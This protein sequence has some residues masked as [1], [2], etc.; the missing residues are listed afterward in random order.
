[1]PEDKYE[2]NNKDNDTKISGKEADSIID[3]LNLEALSRQYDVDRTDEAIAPQPE[4]GD[5]EDE[6]AEQPSEPF[7][8]NKLK[9]KLLDTL[10]TLLLL[11]SLVIFGIPM[12]IGKAKRQFSAALCLLLSLV[13][14]L[15]CVNIGGSYLNAN[16]AVEQTQGAAQ[17]TLEITA[18]A[19]PLLPDS[20]GALQPILKTV[21]FP[22]GMLERYRAIYSINSD[23]VGRLQMPNTSIDTFVMQGKSN[24]SYLRNDFYGKYNRYGNVFLDFRNNPKELSQNSILYGHTTDTELQVF[25]DMYK[26]MDYDFY[27]R[28]PII[29]FG[30]LYKDYRW[31]I[32]AIYISS[33]Q[34]KDDN[35]YFFYYI[36]PEI[37]ESK[38]T[39]YLDQIKQRSRFF[40]DIGVA[41]DDKILTLST[42]VYDNNFT[43]N[44]VD[45]RLVIVA[46]LMREGESS[47]TDPSKVIDNPNFRRPQVWYNHFG[48]KNPYSKSENWEQ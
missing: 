3:S 33:V 18:L 10:G 37:N 29:E 4:N 34:S 36:C 13:I 47:E 28:N 26:Y 8:D 1:M 25:Y 17:E 43:G 35:G 39:G 9:T 22:E 15:S 20:I 44:A 46:R 19:K 24:T 11:F 41:D 16:A 21:T 5:F 27:I 7:P 38:F 42:C 31:K 48:M 30:T 2:N 14:I 12:V 45:S 6:E 23:V 32:F 40:T